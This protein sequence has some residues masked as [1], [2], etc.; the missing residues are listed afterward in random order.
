MNNLVIKRSQLLEAQIV[1]APAAG[2]R[3]Q[4]T[5]IPN[6][7]RNN[8][9]VYGFEVFTAAQLAVTPNNNAVI[10][11]TVADQI[12]LTLVDNKN[13]ELIYQMPYYA[14]IRSQNGGFPIVVKPFILN[15]PRSYV[16]IT[17][18]TGFVANQVASVNI[19]Y[20]IVGE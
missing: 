20:Q 1:G 7:S 18:A 19:Y 16:Q 13:Q 2:K 8:V 3:Y 12:V 17:E 5:E 4:F 6:I 14:A 11:S 15:I 10:P 9:I